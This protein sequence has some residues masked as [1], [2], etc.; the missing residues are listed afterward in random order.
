MAGVLKAPSTEYQAYFCRGC[1]R[2]MPRGFQGHFHPDCLK[3]DKRRRTSEK[4]RVEREKFEAWLAHQQCP[5]CG[6]A[7]RFQNKTA[8]PT[9]GQGRPHV[10]WNDKSINPDTLQS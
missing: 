9:A 7:S 1:A 2:P 6:A 4:R 5:Q 8:D 10:Q 3:A